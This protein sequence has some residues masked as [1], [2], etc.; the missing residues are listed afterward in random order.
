MWFCSFVPQECGRE[1]AVCSLLVWKYNDLNS[2]VILTSSS[3]SSSH[4]ALL[5]RFLIVLTTVAYHF[6][7]YTIARFSASNPSEYSNSLRG[8]SHPT[9]EYRLG[10]KS[11]KVT[12]PLHHI[13][14]SDMTTRSRLLHAALSGLNYGLAMM[15][16]LVVMTY[17]PN[18]F[19]ALVV[20]YAIG[21]YY[22]F[23]KTPVEDPV[24]FD[25]TIND[26]YWY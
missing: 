22:F 16:M 21:D 25:T 13:T 1:V 20:G 24:V 10:V 6:L 11:S 23:I 18:L 7:R 9:V 2:F 5:V 4:L 12:R 14:A 26:M 19:V 15:L 8:G 3:F 17:N